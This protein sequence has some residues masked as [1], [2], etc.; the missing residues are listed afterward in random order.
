MASSP[1]PPA[2]SL[3]ADEEVSA[4]ASGRPAAA[5]ADNNAALLTPSTSADANAFAPLLRWWLPASAS[6]LDGDGGNNNINGDEIILGDGASTPPPR[7][8]LQ[9]SMMTGGGALLN[10]DEAGLFG[11]HYRPPTRAAAAAAA[12]ARRYTSSLQPPTSDDASSSYQQFHQQQFQQQPALPSLPLASSSQIAGAPAAGAATAAGAA[13]TTPAPF[14]HPSNGFAESAYLTLIPLSDA[15]LRPRRT[16]RALAAAAGLFSLL[17]AALAF[18]AAPRGVALTAVD[19][20]ARSLEW[21]ATSG[22]YSL[23]LDAALRL[24]N[25]NYLRARVVGR[26][27]V[28]FYDGRAGGADVGPATL[29]ARSRAQRVLARI[30]ASNVGA[31]YKLKILSDCAAFPRQLVF[32]V[33]GSVRARTAGVFSLFFGGAQDARA[34]DTYFVV[35]CFAAAGREEGERGTPGRL[36]KRGGGEVEEE[37][38]V[39]E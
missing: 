25:P 17:L 27:D 38:E 9:S 12:A 39:E 10:D 35:P 29:P 19:V 7:G 14:P 23:A 6:G 16:P 3:S 34:V 2:S 22:T 33:K 32:F 30:D 18:L 21:N 1:P 13:N 11:E 26:L 5:A 28:F 4:A 31:K 36:V 24:D 8:H 37:E 15:R 20:R